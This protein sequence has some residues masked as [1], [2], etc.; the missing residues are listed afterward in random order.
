MTEV[1]GLVPDVVI[2]LEAAFVS[3]TARNERS[4]RRPEDVTSLVVTGARNPIPR[5]Q[6]RERGIG[7]LAPGEVEEEEEKE[8]G[9]T[10]GWM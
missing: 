9:G 6:R 1:V 3:A 10:I 8:W 2:G 5:S 4:A 7:F